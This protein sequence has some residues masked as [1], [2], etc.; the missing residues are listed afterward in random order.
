MVVGLL[1]QLDNQATHQNKILV[2]FLPKSNDLSGFSCQKNARICPNPTTFQQKV[3]R[4]M[5]LAGYRFVVLL[6]DVQIAHILRPFAPNPATFQ[7]KT[8]SKGSPIKGT[9]AWV[10]TI[11]TL[12]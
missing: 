2:T 5:K 11:F 6:A 4:M 12:Q 1:F 3:D 7:K 9:M 10:L 8:A